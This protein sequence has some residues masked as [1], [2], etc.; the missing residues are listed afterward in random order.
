MRVRSHQPGFTLIELL[1]V[2]VVIAI[3][4]SIGLLS[5]GV[6]GDDRQLRREA[7]RIGSLLEVAQDEA[8]MQGR[9]FGLE[10]M[11]SSYRFV[12]FDPLQRRWADAPADDIFRAR[13]LPENVE[14]DLRLEEKSVQLKLDAVDLSESEKDR[15]RDSR[16][17]Y[18][19]HVLI[20]SSGDTTP[21]QLRLIDTQHDHMVILAGD[22][23]GKIDVLTE[24]EEQ[25]ALLR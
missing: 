13:Q 4:V 21:F 16:K 1:V 17:D 12:E 7:L 19:P 14:F 5:L 24:S 2:V 22:I 3:I 6:L 25:D 23:T 15:E 11:R 10:I 8:I 18:A 9:E 20:F